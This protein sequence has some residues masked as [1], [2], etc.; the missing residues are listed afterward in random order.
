MMEEPMDDNVQMTRVID[1]PKPAAIRREWNLTPSSFGEAMEI[2]KLISESD[3]APRDYRGKPANVLI[4]IQ[5]GLDVGLKPMQA[6]Q[7]IAVVNGKP[8]VYGDAALALALSSGQ[9]ESLKETDDGTTATCSIKRRGLEPVTRTFSMDD[10]KTAGLL[11][12]AG[13]W[14]NYPKR[15]RQMRARG[16]ALRCRIC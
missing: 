16:F 9:I 13:P 15:M 3:F 14:T 7:S 2:A 4:A 1:V 11:G 10:A 12:K 5:Q 6:L 8:S